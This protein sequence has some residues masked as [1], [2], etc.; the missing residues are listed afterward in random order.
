MI[1]FE[2]R[3]IV[4]GAKDEFKKYIEGGGDRLEPL[5]DG[6]VANGVLSKCR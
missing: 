6:V 2:G 5:L 4:M 1:S 3:N